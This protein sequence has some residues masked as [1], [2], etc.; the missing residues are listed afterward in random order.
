MLEP[1]I[2]TSSAFAAFVLALTRVSY[3]QA[4]LAANEVAAAGIALKSGWINADTALAMLDEAGFHFAEPSSGAACD[5]ELIEGV[6]KMR[7]QQ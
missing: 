3:V 1:I 7:G 2:S 4:Q 6:A 5:D